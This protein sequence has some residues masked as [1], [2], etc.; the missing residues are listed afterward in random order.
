MGLVVKGKYAGQRTYSQYLNSQD[1]LYIA[2]A[3]KDHDLHVTKYVTSKECNRYELLTG[4]DA[5][6]ANEYTVRLV[7][8]SG[9]ESVVSLFEWEYRVLINSF[10][11]LGSDYEYEKEVKH[12]NDVNWAWKIAGIVLVGAYCLFYIFGGDW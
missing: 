2:P 7:W 8:K 3:I 10:N 11:F 9:D 1:T 4:N 5:V 12:N 6:R